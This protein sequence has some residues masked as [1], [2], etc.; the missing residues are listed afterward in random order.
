MC[1][2]SSWRCFTFCKSISTARPSDTVDASWNLTFLWAT[3]L[4]S[5]QLLN[6]RS[7]SSLSGSASRFAKCSLSLAKRSVV[8][9][10]PGT[11]V[12]S[13]VWW[14]SYQK[15]AGLSSGKA[16]RQKMQKIMLS[17][18]APAHEAS[19]RK[20]IL[21]FCYST[22]QAISALLSLKNRWDLK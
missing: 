19:S 17:D 15:H 11:D 20:S 4:R 12:S 1:W 22:F 10:L 16:C 9:V 14:A 13:S 7:C 3:M 5:S 8:R 2:C 18:I 6:V 21:G